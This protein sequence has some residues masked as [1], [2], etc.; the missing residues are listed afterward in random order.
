MAFMQKK[1]IALSITITMVL[2]VFAFA[3]LKKNPDIH[4]TQ[5]DLLLATPDELKRH[6]LELF[7]RY[8][9]LGIPKWESWK[10]RC[11]VYLR[12]DCG[13]TNIKD[14]ISFFHF[15][16]GLQ[17]PPQE[18]LFPSQT[19]NSHTGTDA[20][21]PEKDPILQVVYY[22]DA[23]AESILKY[24]LFNKAVLDSRRNGLLN[25]NVNI[26]DMTVPD[27]DPNSI[28]IKTIWQPVFP[29]KQPPEQVRLFI[30][31]KNVP[32]Y[33]NQYPHQLKRLIRWPK[34][35]LD[36]T[37]KT[38]CTLSRNNEGSDIYSLGCFMFREISGD[39]INNLPADVRSYPRI[40]ECEKNTCYLI[41]MGMH[42]MT[43]ET[44]NWVWMTYWW[45]NEGRPATVTSKWDFFDAAA[46]IN[47]Q[48]LE[49]APY[50][51]IANPYLEGPNSGMDLGCL[52]CHRFAAYNPAFTT[53]DA[54]HFF[55]RSF[56]HSKNLQDPQ[57]YFEKALRTHFLWTIARHQDNSLSQSVPPC[58]TKK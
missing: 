35:L 26:S 3:H 55:D 41:F 30:Y 2:A 47:N 1:Y 36:L 33:S 15:L 49:N 27:F 58:E 32:L 48:P 39:E 20:A 44:P 40:G 43:R 21:S 8:T 19:D 6:A 42:M 50:R 25:S 24:Y 10:D 9:T 46:S 51:S 37:E 22:N 4:R 57:C 38:K 7:A 54:I 31:N 17:V 45:T 34:I 13:Q 14:G 29:P 53:D 11:E 28:I 12:D 23:A 5:Q 18:Q 56:L 16:H 52:D